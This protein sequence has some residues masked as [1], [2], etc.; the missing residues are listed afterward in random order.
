MRDQEEIGRKR[1]H[2]TPEEKYQ[3][4]LEGTI[5]KA[6]R[7]VIQGRISKPLMRICPLA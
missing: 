3:I 7:G 5:A 4:F 2:L 6:N 1:R